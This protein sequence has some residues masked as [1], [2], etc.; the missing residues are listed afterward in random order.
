L[1]LPPQNGLI[2]WGGGGRKNDAGWG[3]IGSGSRALK[4]ERG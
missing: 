1:G 2:Q 4:E 3:D